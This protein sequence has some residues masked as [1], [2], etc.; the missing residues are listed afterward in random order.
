MLFNIIIIIIK[1]IESFKPVLVHRTF[2]D[3]IIFWTIL[4]EFPSNLITF[5]L[6]MLPNEE[7]KVNIIC[8]N[9]V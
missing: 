8:L 7:Y 9:K 2:L 5:L 1:D 4:N 3:E 6:K